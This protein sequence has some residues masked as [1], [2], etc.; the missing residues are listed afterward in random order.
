MREINKQLDKG[1]Y[2]AALY[3]AIAK[4]F[5]ALDHDNLIIFSEEVQTA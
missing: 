1:K 5:N 3:L 2:I 4:V